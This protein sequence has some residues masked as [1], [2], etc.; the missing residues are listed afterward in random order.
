MAKRELVDK[1]LKICLRKKKTKTLITK[2]IVHRRHGHN[3]GAR[4][5][6]D[7]HR[8]G[9]GGPGDRPVRR[10]VPLHALD[11][12][13]HGPR[14]RGQSARRTRPPARRQLQFPS[15]RQERQPHLRIA[16]SQFTAGRRHRLGGRAVCRQVG[17]FFHLVRWWMMAWF[18][19]R[20]RNNWVLIWICVWGT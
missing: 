7:A 13:D 5:R 12:L 10:R 18:L 3:V 14:G 8:G 17:S 1:N 19:G 15:G 4:P 20:P 2:P 11:Q 6:L 9:L 16:R